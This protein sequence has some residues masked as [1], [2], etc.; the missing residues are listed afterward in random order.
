[1]EKRDLYTD[2]RRP[3][4]VIPEFQETK[5][6][7]LD[8]S[9]HIHVFHPTWCQ[10]PDL[11]GQ[12]HFKRESEKRRLYEVDCPGVFEPI[13]PSILGGGVRLQSKCWLVARALCL[14]GWELLAVSYNML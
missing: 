6:L 12:L 5:D 13:V 10:P 1:M 14:S 8:F 3:D 4:I 2:Q 9:A 11:L 7:H